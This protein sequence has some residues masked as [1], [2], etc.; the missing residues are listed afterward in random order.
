[1][2][3]KKKRKP[4]VSN[5]INAFVK[6]LISLGTQ[7]SNY[8]IENLIEQNFI[9][10]KIV[11]DRPTLYFTHYQVD[12]KPNSSNRYYPFSTEFIKD[13]EFLKKDDWEL[14]KRLIQEGF[15]PSNI[16]SAIRNDDVEKLQE[17]SSQANFDFNQTIKSSLYERCSFINKGNVSLIDYAAFF[18]SIKCFRFLFLNGST[19]KTTFKYAIAGG[20]HEIIHQCEQNQ[21]IFEGSYESAIEFHRNEIFYYLY[22]NKIIEFND[23]TKLGEE[24]IEHSNY[25]VLE[26]LENE[27]MKIDSSIIET[28]TITGNLLLFKYYNIKIFLQ[29][30]LFSSIESDNF[31]LLKYILKQEGIDINSKDI[32]LFLS[33]FHSII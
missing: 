24:C 11:K 32:L 19:I 29:D 1:M 3:K 25:E 13:I 27:G 21:P 22:E 18:G 15:N 4:N 2:K 10:A 17:T 8:L 28:S 14:H 6:F 33:K 26:Y 5:V 12:F 20:N 16:A 23:F 30:N 31:E 9:E 7:E